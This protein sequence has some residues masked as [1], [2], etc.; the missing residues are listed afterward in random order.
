MCFYVIVLL[1][2]VLVLSV[3]FA[4]SLRVHSNS[5][6]CFFFHLHCSG[7][8]MPVPL[9]GVQG[10]MQMLMQPLTGVPDTTQ[11]GSQNV[12]KIHS[13]V[14]YVG[15]IP[16]CHQV[17]GILRIDK[18]L[19]STLTGKLD[20][21]EAAVVVWILIRIRPN[22]RI[23]DL[24]RT[25]YEEVHDKYVIAADRLKDNWELVSWLRHC[26]RPV[27]YLLVPAKE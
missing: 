7:L 21:D 9:Q 22:F 26:R 8:G 20:Q 2:S 24:R 16:K 19:D 4:S 27:T 17:D 12:H 18:F 5:L 6:E 10:Y 13:G 23:S 11:N 14:Q 1:L 25:N 15:K 3:F